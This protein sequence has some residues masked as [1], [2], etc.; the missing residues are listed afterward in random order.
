VTSLSE[1]LGRPVEMEAAVKAL[2]EGFSGV[3]ALDVR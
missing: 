3:F 1:E 2:I